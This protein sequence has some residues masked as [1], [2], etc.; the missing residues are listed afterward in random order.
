MSAPEGRLLAGRYLLVEQLGRGGMGT[1]WRA[2]DQ[3]L[4]REVA[5]KELTVSGLP[6]EELAVLHARMEQEARA[7]ARV[8]H[9]GV[10]TVFDVLE[11]DGQ[12]W[13][14]MELI[15][16]QSLADV[17]ATEGTL[18]PRDAARL[19][20]QLLAALDRAHQ[21]GVLH[22]DVKPANVLL[23]RGGRVVL[24]DFGIAVMGGSSGLTR[25]GDV[26][27]SPDYLAPERATGHRPGPESDLWSLGVTLYAAVEGQSPFR[28]ATTMS[29][30]QAV[31]AEELPEPR[32]AGP[33]APVIEALLRKDPNE[34]ATAEQA[35]RMLGDVAAGLP[36]SAPAPGTEEHPPTQ[37]ASP[38]PSTGR[39]RF[40]REPTQTTPPTPVPA[41]GLGNRT[42]PGPAAYDEDRASTPPT[43]RIFSADHYAHPGGAGDG[44]PGRRKS[45]LIA[46]A[47]LAVALVGGG[48]AA[49]VMTS[50]SGGTPQSAPATSSTPTASS[51]LATS[52]STVTSENTVT[53]L[54]TVTRTA[55]QSPP[56]KAEEPP[57]PAQ[58][59]PAPTSASPTTT[60][61]AP[62]QQV[63]E[64]YFAAINA[65]DYP[66]AWDLGAK[67]LGGTYD[68]FVKGLSDTVSDTVTIDSVSGDTVAMRLD[69]LQTDGTHQLFAGTYTVRDGVIVS[70]DVEEQ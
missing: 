2:Q 30:L 64:K 40:A 56:T 19:G 69:A 8:K 55:T 39:E 17:I 67:N 36:V 24:T 70:A 10:V 6:R 4:S 14:V 66:H 38:T 13:I 37:L 35:Q 32:H 65:G 62:A 34:R 42:E 11:E 25:T 54:A 7:A 59:T 68:S 28:R 47:A 15:D 29:T 21:L 27:G 52:E 43:V 20:A 63:V 51:A 61:V 57:A 46:G 16:G 49:V 58:P 45:L 50:H 60:A 26:V 44:R 1:V 5:V 53:S 18:L 9:P 23:E 22:R 12:P 41:Y 31:V 48:A 33:L 3:V